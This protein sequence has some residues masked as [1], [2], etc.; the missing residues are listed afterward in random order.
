M[1]LNWHA[2]YRK[3]YWTNRL[4]LRVFYYRY[5]HKLDTLNQFKNV[6]TLIKIFIYDIF[7]C[8]NNLFLCN[9]INF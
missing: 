2:Q 3:K 9:F 5:P 6:K 1:F 4:F 8:K 7:I